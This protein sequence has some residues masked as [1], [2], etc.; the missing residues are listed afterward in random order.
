M[1]PDGLAASK[2]L[3]RLQ[4]RISMPIA[5]LAWTGFP[6]TRKSRQ[7]KL[8]SW[9]SASAATSRFERHSSPMSAQRSATTARAFM[10]ASSVR[11]PMPDRW[12]AQEKSDV[13]HLS[14]EVQ[15]TDL[16][17]KHF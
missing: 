15:I 14:M 17:A 3:Q 6:Y 5:A 11:T 9:V 7:G 13:D 4:S 16:Q 1:T 8:V 12:P 10:M 2:T